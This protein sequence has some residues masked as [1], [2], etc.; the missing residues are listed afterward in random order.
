[1]SGWVALT[2]RP[3]RALRPVAVRFRPLRQRRWVPPGALHFAEFD[4]AF[5]PGAAS[6][7]TPLA[8]TS[9]FD[10]FLSGDGLNP[11]LWSD[12]GAQAVTVEDG[13]LTVGDPD[14]G[15]TDV[16]TANL[17]NLERGSVTIEALIERTD[18]YVAFIVEAPAEGFEA[19]PHFSFGLVAENGIV[20]WSLVGD[21]TTGATIGSFTAADWRFLRV[22]SDPADPTQIT[23]RRSA[24]ARTWT[25]L[26]TVTV[27]D[28]T[29]LRGVVVRFEGDSGG[30]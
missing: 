30:S 29:K 17:L 11:V 27:V 26:G 23:A 12:T 1:M 21:T 24:N 9:L 7:T 6:G 20:S 19:T 28:T 15:A 18:A 10:R 13:A 22:S 2:R 4:T 5:S 16:Q 8:A 25:V 3:R 14:D